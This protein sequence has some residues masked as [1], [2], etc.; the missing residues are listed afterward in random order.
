[1]RKSLSGFL[2][3]VLLGLPSLLHLRVPLLLGAALLLGGAVPAMAAGQSADPKLVARARALLAP[4]PLL[5]THD[6][7]PTNL[8]EKYKGDLT[9]LALA[10]V[11][12]SLSADVPRLIE[13]GVGAQYWSVFVESPTMGT[14]A[15]LHEALREFDVTL[16]LIRS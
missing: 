1:M 2:V 4:A 9:K 7:L 8:L 13:G 5:D 6:D 11:Q 16:R 15:A 3:S 10:K 14:H 12:T